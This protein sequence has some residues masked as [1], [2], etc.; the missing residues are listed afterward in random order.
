MPV[1]HKFCDDGGG[2][3]CRYTRI[4]DVVIIRKKKK[5]AAGGDAG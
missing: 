5:E 1:G 2:E 4:D 3:R